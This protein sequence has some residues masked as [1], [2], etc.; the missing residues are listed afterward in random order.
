MAGKSSNDRK[1]HPSVHLLRPDQRSHL[2][3]KSTRTRASKA[4][5]NTYGNLREERKG[6]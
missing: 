3:E 4:G 1:C 2:D 6:K 5:N